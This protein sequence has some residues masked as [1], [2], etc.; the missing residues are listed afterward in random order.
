[1]GENGKM[2]VR[3]LGEIGSIL[4]RCFIF[5]F[6]R[7]AIELNTKSIMRQKTYINKGTVLRGRNYVGKG[8]VLTNVDLGFGSY[9][10]ANGDLSNARVG[11]YCSIGPRLSSIGGNHPLKEFV[12]THPAFYASSNGAGFSYMTE[13]NDR[14]EEKSDAIFSEDKYIDEGKGYFYEIGNDVWIG[15]NVSICQGVKIG[16][17]A[18]VGACSLV[19][20]DVEPYAIYAGVPA[21]KIGQRFSDEEI[22]KLLEMKWWDKDEAWI[23][24]HAAEFRNAKEFVLNQDK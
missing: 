24:L 10:S 22:S 7:I 5:P 19:N 8:T 21:K 2:L 23:K 12:S 4:Y 16:D 9:I 1:M 17:G 15:A 18:V 14:L 3:K 13:I 11:K 6:K 20:K